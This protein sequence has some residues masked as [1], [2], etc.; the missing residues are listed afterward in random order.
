V[1][2]CDRK[3]LVKTIKECALPLNGKIKED[4]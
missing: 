2:F 1:W 3:E 4:L